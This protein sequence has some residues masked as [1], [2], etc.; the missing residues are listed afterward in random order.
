MFKQLT[1]I[2]LMLAF[3]VQTFNRAVIVV[4]YYANTAAYAKNCIN[5]ARPAMHCNGKC[6]VMKKI[7]EEEKKDQENAERKDAGKGNKLTCSN[8]FLTTLQSPSS[9]E[10]PVIIISR[11]KAGY[12]FD[13]SLDIFHPPRV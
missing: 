6:Q 12:C 9:T 1:A 5:K 10:L 11:N 7:Q 3:A 13:R 4:D 2:F 8:A